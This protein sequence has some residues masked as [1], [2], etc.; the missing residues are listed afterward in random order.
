MAA[1]LGFVRVLYRVGVGSDLPRRESPAQIGRV[2]NYVMVACRP[3]DTEL[4]Y[5]TTESC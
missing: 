5:V 2:G 4:S 1:E 3:R